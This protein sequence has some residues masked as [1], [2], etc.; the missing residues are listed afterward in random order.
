MALLLLD[1]YKLKIQYYA[2][3]FVL[4]NANTLFYLAINR[5][6]IQFYASRLSM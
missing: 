4:T 1:E 6:G 2:I 3:Y 5:T